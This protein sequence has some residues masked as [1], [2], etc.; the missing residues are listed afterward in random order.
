[1]TR[2]QYSA[3]PMNRSEPRRREQG[4]LTGATAADVRAALRR[5]GLQVVDLRPVTERTRE[6]AGGAALSLSFAGGLRR[7]VDRHL[8]RRR[9]AL[10]SD[11]YDSLATLLEAGVPLSQAIESARRASHRK[12][13][14]IGR[15][16]VHLGEEVKRGESIDEAMRGC[17]DWF[18]D[19]EIAM[20]SAAAQAGTLSDVLHTLSE[21]HER[22]GEVTQ[23]L[24]AAM[25]YPLVIVIIGLAVS[26]FLSTHTL[27]ELVSMLRGS[28][29]EPPTLT[30]I[31]MNV[32]GNL[33]AYGVWAGLAL[34]AVVVA[35]VFIGRAGAGLSR[36]HRTSRFG[37]IVRRVMTGPLVRRRI[38][39]A[40]ALMQL[41]ELVRVGVT[42]PEALRIAGPVSGQADLGQLLCDAAR[43]IEN[44]EAPAAALDD[45]LWFD[46]EFCRLV[47][48][49]QES[50]ELEPVFERLGNRYVRQSTRLIDRLSA[51]LEPAIILA[52]AVLVGLVAMAAVLPLVR[53]RE[54]V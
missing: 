20:V 16:L 52:L 14:A 6:G 32:G 1:M 36:D 29:I 34:A 33:L 27:P 42:L 12:A 46:D 9:V 10:R 40:R 18:D 50:G 49:A 4:E 11:L 45:T 25:A 13:R 54:I 43:R 39:L 53:L 30:L 15:M 48:L 2:W 38:A 51:L 41:A 37:L 35:L 28:G 47:E 24:A 17:P 7:L 23:K 44:G 31:V 26:V 21:R 8:Q 22:T 5:I 3:V 19:A